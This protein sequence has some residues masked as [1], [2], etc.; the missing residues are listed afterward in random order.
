MPAPRSP[1][2]YLRARVD[3]LDEHWLEL[4]CG[5]GAKVFYPFKLLAQ[6]CGANRVDEVH[7]GFRCRHCGGRP[8]RV[9][10][11]N[12]PA[13]GPQYP[14]GRYVTLVDKAAG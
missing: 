12:N 9:G 13:R 14:S 11:T 8:V 4:E 3:E 6:R 2:A 7:G 10:V 1:E 5:W